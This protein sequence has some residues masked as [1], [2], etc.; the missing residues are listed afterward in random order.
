MGTIGE[1]QV[2]SDG[3]VYVRLTGNPQLCV[4]GT[5]EKA[6]FARIKK[7]DFSFRDAEAVR[8]QLA[9]IT[10]AKLSGR[11]VK[12]VVQDWTNVATGGFDSAEFCTLLTVGLP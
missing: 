5:P 8:S 3:S 9:T 7:G 6:T 12:L 10:A 1:L 11:T 2:W 4:G